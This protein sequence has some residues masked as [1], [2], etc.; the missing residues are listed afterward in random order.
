MDTLKENNLKNVE[1]LNKSKELLT[2][3]NQKIEEFKKEMETLKQAAAQK[4]QQLS[5]LQKEKVKLN[6]ELGRSRD[7]L[8]S[9]QKLEERPVHF[10]NQLLEMKKRESKLIKDADEEKAS[11]QKSI[12][13]TT[14]LLIEKDAGRKS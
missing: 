11:L 10:N 6:E 7:E 12:S 1:E 13:I 5:A 2:V 3:E 8:T 4:S 14:A 9:H